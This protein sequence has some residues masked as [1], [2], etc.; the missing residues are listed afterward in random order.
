MDLSGLKD[1]KTTIPGLIIAA[2]A[3]YALISGK[4]SYAEWQTVVL[5]V[6]ALIG[7]GAL[8]LT[9]KKKPGEDK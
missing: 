2:G 1:L 9:G 3:T 5:A 6:L 8:M 4:C 7:G